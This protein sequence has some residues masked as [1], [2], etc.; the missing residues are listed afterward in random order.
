MYLLFVDESGTHGGSHAFV[1]GG[2]AIHEDDAPRL[3]RALDSLVTKHLGR[4][5]LNL[6]EYE[7]HAGEMRNAKKPAAGA[8]LT[9][10]ASIWAAYPRAMRMRLLSAAYKL[11]ANFRPSHVGQPPALFGV[12]LDKAFHNNWSPLQREQFAYEVL[13]NKF[14]VMLKLMRKDAKLPN[15]GL[16]IHDERVVAERDIQAWTT[17]WRHAAGK[18]GQLHN[19]ADVPLFTDSRA[20]RLLQ[21]A[22]LV[23]YALYRHYDPN[24]SGV[25][26]F[27]QLWPMF[28][29]QDG[30]THGC[31]HFTPSFGQGACTCS[32]CEQRLLAEASKQTRA[33][34]KR[35]RSGVPIDLT[36]AE[37]QVVLP[38]PTIGMAAEGTT[39]T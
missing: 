29:T 16:V 24:R 39:P 15:R 11:V 4:V 35:T 18:I 7:L 23:S 17:E 22:D 14:D 31:V 10:K 26:Y 34:R 25:D 5:P 3:Q 9:K 12:V 33:P 8:I 13:L 1:L 32:P 38:E 28:A 30:T 20:T 21:V 36:Q 2:L 6:D 19:L 37:G 27:P